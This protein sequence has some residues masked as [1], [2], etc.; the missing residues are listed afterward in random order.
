DPLVVPA[1]T[2]AV[3]RACF[4]QRRK[5]IGGLLRGKLPDGGAAWLAQLTAAGLSAAARPEQ[6]PVALW[7]QL[8][9]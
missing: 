7:R 9:V 5:Q 8:A 6:I 4:Q 2:K 3:I 1:A